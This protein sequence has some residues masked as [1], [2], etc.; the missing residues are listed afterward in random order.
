MAFKIRAE[1]EDTVIDAVGQNAPSNKSMVWN[2]LISDN[3]TCDSKQV[4]L[5]DKQLAM[6]LEFLLDFD[7][8][9]AG[10]EEYHK[11]LDPIF[12]YWPNHLRPIP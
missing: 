6:V 11:V 1:F 9:P 8:T 7:G 5:T 12:K 3:L 2:C 10:H 4:T